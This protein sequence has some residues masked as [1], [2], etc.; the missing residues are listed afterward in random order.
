MSLAS[1]PSELILD[2]GKLVPNPDLSALIL[3]STF[4]ANLLTPQICNN[5]LLRDA[6]WSDGRRSQPPDQISKATKIKLAN[7]I[8]RDAA[9]WQ[10]TRILT[11][12]SSLPLETLKDRIYVWDDNENQPRRAWLNRLYL[13]APYLRI[14][15]R[16]Y[17]PENLFTSLVRARSDIVAN[18]LLE[19]ILA[20][21]R[22]KRSFVPWRLTYE[23]TEAIRTCLK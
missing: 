1:L 8:F 10:S 22:L 2:I 17:R 23:L 9:H 15:E 14:T 20:S 18:V 3:T 13:A 12:F 5:A 11:Y 4:L 21:Q 6:A 19:W 16:F 7:R